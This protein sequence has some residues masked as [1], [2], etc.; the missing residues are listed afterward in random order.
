MEALVRHPHA[1]RRVAA[2]VSWAGAA[3]GSP[4]ADDMNGLEKSVL[5]HLPL[6]TCRAGD[7]SEIEALRRE[8]RH[9]WWQANHQRLHVP[10]YSMV[11]LPD[12]GHISVPLRGTYKKLAHIDA[13][14]DGQIVA[15]DA[16]VPGSALLGYVNADHWA[17]AI[18]LSQQL[19]LLRGLFIDDVP[20][21]KLA[22]AII[23]VVHQQATH[24]RP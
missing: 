16:I 19:P 11:A 4:L 20:R 2:V 21:T 10:F 5:E 14:N 13:N 7:G 18:A 6:A 22:L 12:P 3:G 1:M 9:G 8:V 17:I 15:S 23:A 24:P